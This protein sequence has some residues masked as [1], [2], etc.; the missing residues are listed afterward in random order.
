MNF[1]I[2][3]H[4]LSVFHAVVDE[5]SLSKAGDRLFMSQPAISAHIKA[6]ERQLGLPLFYR[7][8]RRSVVNKAG[9]ALYKRA[10]ELLSMA[11][12]VQVEMENLR[13]IG[14]GRLILGASV[15]WHYRLPLALDRFKRIYP[16]VEISLGIGNSDRIE[17][18]ILDRALDFGFIAR[19]S[20]RRDLASQQL[21]TEDLAPTCSSS[22]RFAEMVNIDVRESKDESFIVREPGSATRRATDELLQ[23]HGLAQNISMELG[24]SE[25]IKKAVM[26]GKGIGI[27]A[28]TSLESELR[29]GLLAVADVPKLKRELELHMVRHLHRR[30]TDTQAA[31]LE[32]VTSTDFQ[33][34]HA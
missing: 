2:D 22:H 11:E 21:T 10:E 23:A 9:E 13:G 20:P 19:P 14:S 28:K 17:K 16:V 7:E 1:N 24:S 4:R 29:A 34:V 6:L 12:R 18:Q 15:D 25:A 5:G 30:L 3:L 27:V 26:A 33:P 31:F 32:L 8:G